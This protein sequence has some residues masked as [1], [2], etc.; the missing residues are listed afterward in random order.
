M[1]CGYVR[2]GVLVGFGAAVRAIVAWAL[3][4]GAGLGSG[5]EGYVGPIEEMRRWT[6]A[7]GG[8]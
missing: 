1:D 8:G 4:R 6:E 2:A 3:L 5:W 7:V